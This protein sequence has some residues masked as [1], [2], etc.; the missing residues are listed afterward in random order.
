MFKQYELKPTKK[1]EKNV[2]KL[3]TKTQELLW[4]AIEKL[5]NGKKLEAHYKDHKLKGKL[6]EYRE[7][8][9]RGDVLLMY[10]IRKNELILILAD[11]GSHCGVLGM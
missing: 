9:I 10:Q 1:F 6:K 5:Q 11:V 3:D 7:C 4:I 8:H 2:I